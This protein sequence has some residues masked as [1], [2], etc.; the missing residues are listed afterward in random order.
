MNE[1][2]LLRTANS[3]YSTVR[4][5]VGLGNPGSQYDGTRHNIGFE[6]VDALAR[7]HQVEFSFCSKWN[8]DLAKVS[9]QGIGDLWL[10]KPRTFMNLSGTAVASFAHFYKLVPAEV[11]IVLDD[12]M[13]CLGKIRLRCSGSSGGQR[14]LESVLRHFSTEAVPRL[15]LGIGA[16]PLELEEREKKKSLQMTLSDY[17]LSRFELQEQP[18]VEAAVQQAVEVIKMI[19]EQG[20]KMAMNLF[21]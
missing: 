21:N 15:R 18:L 14:G 7:Q 6:V 3:D 12:V 17:V 10:M 16:V 19:Q 11:L 1:Q 8:A 20:V 13:L 4:V 9:Q 2:E 5:V